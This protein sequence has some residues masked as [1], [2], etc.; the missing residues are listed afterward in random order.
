MKQNKV[1]D[2]EYGYKPRKIILARNHGTL[3]WG[4]SK[5][6]K[7]LFFWI[8]CENRANKIKESKELSLVSD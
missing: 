2:R 7:K 4:K 1:K 6:G 5:S 8:Y 3:D